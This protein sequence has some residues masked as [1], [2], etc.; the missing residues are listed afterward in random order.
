MGINGLGGR[1]AR[2]GANLGRNERMNELNERERMNEGGL[3]ERTESLYWEGTMVVNVTT[4]TNDQR[5]HE[6]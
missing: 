3:K 2:R 5:R 6:G 4:I 1:T